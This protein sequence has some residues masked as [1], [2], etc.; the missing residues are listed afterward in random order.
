MDEWFYKRRGFRVYLR[1]PRRS[2][3]PEYEIYARQS[4]AHLKPWVY[5]ITSKEKYDAYAARANSDRHQSFY[6]CQIESDEILG[7]INFNEIVRGCLHGCFSGFYLFAHGAGV[8]YMREGLGLALQFGFTEL[9][10]HRVEAN[11]QPGNKRSIA[12]V[13]GL[14]F[15]LEGFSP[16]YLKIGPTWC[17]HERWAII[18]EEF[19][20]SQVLRKR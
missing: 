5:P 17:D 14:G 9:K 16:R 12:L 13:K 11:I 10:L 2:D 18:K 1:R 4:A 15:R 3:W 20:F 6:I 7:V 8:G 19:K